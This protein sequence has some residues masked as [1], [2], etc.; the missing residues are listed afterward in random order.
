MYVDDVLIDNSNVHSLRTK[1]GYIPQDIYLFDGT[2]GENVAFALEYNEERIK[3]VLKKAR[4]FEYFNQKEGL[5]TLVGEGGIM[6]SG[7][8]KQRIGIA[9]ALYT[10]PEILI[11]DEA[12]SALDSETEAE[13][14]EEIYDVSHDKTLIIIAHRL[15]TIDKCDFIYRLESGQ[16]INQKVVYERD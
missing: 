6:L 8:Q 12:T 1:I 13:I 9:R 16:I 4:I 3:D 2:V 10:N 11:L 15:S 14:M 7:G 5:N